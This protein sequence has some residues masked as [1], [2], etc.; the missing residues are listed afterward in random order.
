M[1]QLQNLSSHSPATALRLFEPYWRTLAVAIVVDLSKRPQICQQVCDLL[2]IAVQRFLVMTQSYTIPFLILTKRRDILQRIA[3]ANGPDDS[4]MSICLEEEQ[5]AA[6]LASLLLNTSSEPDATIASL[7]S[8][9]SPEF[10]DI[11]IQEIFRSDPTRIAFELLKAA[12]G[13]N[14]GIQLR[15]R[16][17]ISVLAERVQRKGSKK[18]DAVAVFFEESA[19]GIVQLLSEIISQTKGPQPISDRKGC[20]GALQ[21]MAIIAKSHLC[22][23]LPQVSI[24]Q[25]HCR[26]LMWSGYVLFTISYRRR[27]SFQ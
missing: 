19:L 16:Q 7:L 12:G 24:S 13:S 9:A 26:F 3:A 15:A 2:G 25:L 23:A 6:I 17:G 27:H 20:I 21:Q 8:E 14:E 4:I 11:D 10:R 1:I 22:N 5:L 18:Q